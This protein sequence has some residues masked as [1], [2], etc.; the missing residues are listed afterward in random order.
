MS[1]VSGKRIIVSA[2]ASGNLDYADPARFR[3][4]RKIGNDDV[5][6]PAVSGLP[7]YGVLQNLPR[8][9]EHASVCIEGPTKLTFGAS[10]GADAPIMSNA[11][12]FAILATSGQYTAG[13]TIQAADSGKIGQAYISMT[14]IWSS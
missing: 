3:F 12:G 10:L 4:V 1:V 7:V 8:D 9:N 13:R 2:I 5:L 11:T 14:G 6:Q